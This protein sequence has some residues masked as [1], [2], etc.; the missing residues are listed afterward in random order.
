VVA[1][2]VGETYRGRL[3]EIAFAGLELELSGGGVLRLA[4]E[5][6]GHL[7]EAPH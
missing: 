6:V 5:T 7:D 2:C 1:E 4:P 3:R